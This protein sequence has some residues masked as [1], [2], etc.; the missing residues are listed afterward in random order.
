MNR[1][2][3]AILA[4]CAILLGLCVTASA[5][6]VVT[7]DIAVVLC[8]GIVPDEVQS[9]NATFHMAYEGR[10]D[11][12][13]R[14]VAADIVRNPMSIAPREECLT[15]WRLPFVNSK[16]LVWMTWTH[17]QGWTSILA[18]PSGTKGVSI[19]I[20]PGWGSGLGGRIN[21]ITLCRF[22]ATRGPRR[23]RA[24]KTTYALDLAPDGSVRR[25]S[26]TEGRNGEVEKALAG[27]LA[28][29]RLPWEISRIEVNTTGDEGLGWTTLTVE[30]PTGRRTF[31]VVR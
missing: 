12:E 6:E 19:N 1:P 4:N 17:A 3:S 26:V 29:W 2:A 24:S 28:Q 14:V 31:R 21:E 11:S 7:A 30:A 10:T 27:C 8:A 20:R 15:R 22:R 18:S 16:V 9:A 23:H 13:G 25:V 5:S